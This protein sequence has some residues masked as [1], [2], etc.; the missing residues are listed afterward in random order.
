MSAA[1][2]QTAYEAKWA[3]YQSAMHQGAW[4]IGWGF[5]F[6]TVGLLPMMWFF[7]WMV[8]ARNWERAVFHAP[9]LMWAAVPLNLVVVAALLFRLYRR[10]LELDALK[11]RY[12][13]ELRALKPASP[14]HEPEAPA[15]PDPDAFRDDH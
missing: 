7:I 12:L 4:R 6:V 9:L 3:E 15:G 13:A 5:F 1:D 10:N 8:G 2:P 14:A 11:R